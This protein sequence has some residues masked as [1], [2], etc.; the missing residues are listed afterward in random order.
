MI[1]EMLDVAD[2]PTLEHDEAMAIAAVEYQRLLEL[3]D[4]FGPEDWARE[5]DCPGWDVKD[6]VAHL[7]GWMKANAD[8]AEAGRQLAV[9]ARE[10]EEQEILRLNAQTALHVREHAHLTPAELSAAVHEWAGLALEGRTGATAELRE[11]TFSTGLPGEPDWTRGYLIDVVFTRDVWMHRLDLC[12]ATGHPMRITPDHDG[13]IVA[14]V[15][16]DWARR[17]AQPFALRLD[18]PAGGTFTGGQG[19]PELRSDAVE[20][21]RILSGRGSSDG[22]LATFVPF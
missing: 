1:I 16:A 9:A 6:V 3:V 14:D 8:P 5:T 18:G 11:G 22:L 4:R 12:R 20:F 10:A 15:V 13:R 19:G 7:L 21:C 2:I 17:H